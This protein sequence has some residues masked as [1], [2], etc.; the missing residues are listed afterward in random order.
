MQEKK[1]NHDL[2]SYIYPYE[3][4]L[5]TTFRKNGEPMPTTVW[6]TTNNQRIYITTIT[7]AG[8]IKRLRNNKQVELAPC[9]RVGTVLG[10]TITAQAQELPASE[11]ERINNLFL[12]KYGQQY[13]AARA[14]RAAAG[15]G[16]R[17]FIEVVP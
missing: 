6:F 7:A 11:H 4:L 12:Q 3:F 8:K 13:E 17:T 5:F 9:D 2:F 1:T 16:E 14:R 15:T 10:T